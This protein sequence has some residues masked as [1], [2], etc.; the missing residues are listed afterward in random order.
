MSIAQEGQDCNSVFFVLE[1]K[2]C[3]GMRGKKLVS[4]PRADASDMT[5]GVM[6]AKAMSC[7]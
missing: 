1:I 7:A 6:N 4:I 5:A 3:M 2:G